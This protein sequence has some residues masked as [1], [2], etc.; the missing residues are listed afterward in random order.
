ML[1]DSL[2]GEVILPQTHAPTQFTKTAKPQSVSPVTQGFEPEQGF[3]TPQPQFNR[4]L[5]PA[6]I[7]YLQRTVG[8][9][10]VARML[11]AQRQLRPQHSRMLPSSALNPI[12]PAVPQVQ[13]SPFHHSLIQRK[14]SNWSKFKDFAKGQG[15]GFKG[16][17]QW[18]MDEMN[19]SNNKGV[20]K[21]GKPL[22]TS[23]FAALQMGI[24]GVGRGLATLGAGA[25]YGAKGLGSGLYSGGKAIAG[26]LKSTFAPDNPNQYDRER[27]P[28]RGYVAAN[29]L[30]PAVAVG[31]S[32]GTGLGIMGG[33]SAGL[34][35]AGTAIGGGMISALGLIPA[36]G[37]LSTGNKRE[38]QAKQN[39][40]LAGQRVG[41]LIAGQGKVGIGA[42]LVGT[43]GAAVNAATAIQHGTGAMMTAD[44]LISGASYASTGLGVAGA[45]LGIAGG[46]IT[47]AQGLWKSGSAASKLWKLRGAG[48][49]MLTQ[50]GQE[51]KNRVK[52][53]EKSKLMMNSLKVIGSALGIAAG[54]LLLASNPVGWAL[55]IAGAITLGG[56]AAYKIYTKVKKY[57][58]KQKNKNSVRQAMQSESE[59]DAPE[60]AL[61]GAEPE[62]EVDNEG[63]GGGGGEGSGMEQADPTKLS[64]T[65][66]KQGVDLANRVAQRAS[67]SAKVAGEMIT[68]LKMSNPLNIVNALRGG[69]KLSDLKQFDNDDENQRVRQVDLQGMDAA[70]LIKVLN[71]KPEEALSESGQ[72]LIEKKMSA[73]DTL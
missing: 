53:R 51:W 3:D 16:D 6:D 31:A 68:A 4:L 44:K 22:L 18:W 57:R 32:A 35:S 70:A 72:E 14:D 48:A 29:A 20:G 12:S 73:T 33:G 61:E 11:A 52:D 58:R 62:G 59:Q 5:R 60:Q 39:N 50:K 10:Q 2:C 45:A 23:P 30:K 65:Q 69:M 27:L 17:Q 63:G 36:L 71:I 28:T 54:A 41:K 15:R 1:T 46:S 38:K 34:D 66:R 13:R 64:E 55:G 21:V 26:G 24:S 67:K 19:P 47:A 8:N 9:R 56:L 25:Y 42:G 43:A 37:A 49:E 40:D 7:P